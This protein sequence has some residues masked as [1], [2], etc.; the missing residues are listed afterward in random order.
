MRF[1]AVRAVREHLAE[2]PERL[3]E[4]LNEGIIST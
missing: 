4:F 2:H 1:L 3:E